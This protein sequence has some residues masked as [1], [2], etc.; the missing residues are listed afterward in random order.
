LT[1]LGLVIFSGKSKVAKTHNDEEKSK[2]AY[3]LSMVFAALRLGW[4]SLGTHMERCPTVLQDGFTRLGGS[5][6]EKM[7]FK[8]FSFS[9]DT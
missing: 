1:A 8:Y 4:F 5:P 6:T 2:G 9:A 3:K 7:A